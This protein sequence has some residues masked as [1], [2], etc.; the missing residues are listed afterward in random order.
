MTVFELKFD[1]AFAVKEMLNILSLICILFSWW[2]LVEKSWGIVQTYPLVV[3]FYS[4][5]NQVR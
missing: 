1:F 3:P 5:F 4:D 2:S